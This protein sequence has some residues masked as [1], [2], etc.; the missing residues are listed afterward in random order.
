MPEDQERSGV[1]AGPARRRAR[2]LGIA[3]LV[4]AGC[5]GQAASAA[6]QA[7]P[8]RRANL[9]IGAEGPLRGDG[10]LAGYAFFLLNR[11]HFIDDDFYL[12]VI[13]A[14]TYF[15]ADLVRDRWPADGHALGIGL[16]GGFFPYNFEEFR[17]GQH[18]ER[19]SFWGHGGETTL[20]YYR[21]TSLFERLPVEGQLRLRPQLVVYQHGMDTDSRFRLPA[22][23]VLYTGR[24]GI[25]VGGVPPELLPELAL[26]ASIWYEPSY[27]TE[28]GPFGLPERPQETEHFTQRAWARV[29][30][31]F[32]V[33]RGHTVQ[34]FFTAGT[35]EDTDALSAFRL[36]SALP[37]RSEF[38]LVLHGYFVDEVF[39]RRFWLVNLA[40]RI[41]LWNGAERVKLQLSLD[42]ARVDYLEGHELPRHGL[43]GAG[44]DLS[45][46]LTRDVTLMLGYGYGWD[47]P[48]NGGFGGHEAH[49]LLELKF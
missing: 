19:E 6:A 11:P 3:A 48:R 46:A 14:P 22:D 4:L 40:Y 34:G 2:R 18:R 47:A 9:E 5:L 26:E 1:E 15:M 38:P 43:R 30:G 28:A 36:G 21:R 41:P 7:D 13:F 44:A 42:Y 25:R 17:S 27:R 33:S 20:S 16:A 24:A 35:T 31:V 49:T 37:F 45:I 12:R 10:P 8:Q 32:A 23:T 29:G 39:A